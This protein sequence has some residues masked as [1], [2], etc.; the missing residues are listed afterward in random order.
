MFVIH[1]I[2]RAFDTGE[3]ASSESCE[4][5]GPF[6]SQ[7][8]FSAECVVASRGCEFLL[9]LMETDLSFT[10]GILWADTAF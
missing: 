1:G 2:N 8:C 10:V 6:S 4:R 5:T 3:E 9:W 7:F